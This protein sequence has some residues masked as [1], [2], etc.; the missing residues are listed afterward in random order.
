[1]KKLIITFAMVAS[2]VAFAGDPA[3]AVSPSPTGTTSEKSAKPRL[4]PAERQARR[5]AK[6]AADGG[7]LNRPV[8]GRVVRIMVKTD[9]ISIGEVEQEAAQMS[10][11]LR[12]AVEVVDSDDASRNPTG[13]LIILAEQEKGPT[14]LVAPEDFWATVN[15]K[16]LASDNPSPEVLRSRIV[17][18]LWRGFAYALGAANSMQQPCIMRPIRKPSDLD[19][20]KVSILPPE[21]LMAVSRTVALLDFAQGGQTTYKTAVREGWAPQPTNDVQKAIWDEI[22]SV[23]TKPIT[24]EPE[25]K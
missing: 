5:A 9:K 20:E 11:L 15:V 14:L 1:M 17:K 22:H 24:I 2:V 21:P 25:K 6:I 19:S 10:K 7:M 3:P 8:H 4:T 13:A 16:N 18:E 12:I 23:P